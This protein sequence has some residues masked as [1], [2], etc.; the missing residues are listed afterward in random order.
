MEDFIEKTLQLIALERD[1]EI[2]EYQT[3]ISTELSN[4]SK[5]EARGIC[6]SKL[7]VSVPP[8]ITCSTDYLILINRWCHNTLDSM[9]DLLCYLN[10]VCESPQVHVHPAASHQVP[11]IMIHAMVYLSL[12][13]DVS[14]YL[15]FTAVGL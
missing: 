5:L 10:K 13:G 4:P 15:I 7:E 14:K 2:Q 3:N 6:V 9:A 12:F 1:T 8:Y 11:C